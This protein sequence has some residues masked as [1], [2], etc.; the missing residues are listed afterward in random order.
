[1]SFVAAP[2]LTPAGLAR[3]KADSQATVATVACAALRARAGRAVDAAAAGHQPGQ[4]LSTVEAALV[5]ALA[6]WALALVATRTVYLAEPADPSV[7]QPSSAMTLAASWRRFIGPT[8]AGRS[9]R[10]WRSCLPDT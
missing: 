3:S 4:S 7:A 8:L 6:A 10:F 1:M 5:A 9:G 2:V